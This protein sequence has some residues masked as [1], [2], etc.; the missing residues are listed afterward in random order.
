MRAQ[1]ATRPCDVDLGSAVHTLAER[2]ADAAVWALIQEAE[3]TPKPALVDGRGFGAHPDLSLEIMRCSARSLR[4]A[5]LA[6]AQLAPGRAI[7]RDL[8]EALAQ[9]GRDG[10][11]AMLAAT[12]GANAHRGAIWALGLLTAAVAL[13]PTGSVDEIGRRAAAIARL[14]DRY[15]PASPSHGQSVAARYGVPG[16][17][18]EAQAGFPHALAI[19]L[20]TLR[21]VR[22]GGG[23]ETQARLDALMAIM[24]A[25]DDTCLLHRAGREGLAA[26]QTGARAVLMAG[27]AGAPEG[28][29]ALDQL[30][31][32]LMALNASPG[33]GADML[34]A[35]LFIDAVTDTPPARSET[36]TPRSEIH[37]WKS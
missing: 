21:R 32:E 17:R 11:R 22:A 25:M 4:P 13:E 37:P 7:D 29:L 16:A 30:H 19:G 23:S 5:F 33:G 27:G 14:P 31:T 3:L 24:A 2:L 20:P 36:R 9:I 28:R 35:A 34:A 12:G 1:L 18:G 6:M 8:R 26:A 10:E 15:I